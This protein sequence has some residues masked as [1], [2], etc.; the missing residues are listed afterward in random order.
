MAT[1]RTLRYVSDVAFSI[2]TAWP[3][4][5]IIGQVS[6]LEMEYIMMHPALLDSLTTFMLYDDGA[7]SSRNTPSFEKVTSFVSGSRN[8]TEGD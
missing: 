7:L 4:C 6:V 2:H 8:R 5:K 1:L 3:R